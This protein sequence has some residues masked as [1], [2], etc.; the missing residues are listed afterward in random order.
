MIQLIL[1]RNA[2]EAQ[3][4]IQLVL[5]VFFPSFLSV[6]GPEAHVETLRQVIDQCIYIILLYVCHSLLAKL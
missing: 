3:L 2:A 1:A 4:E 5:I 6:C